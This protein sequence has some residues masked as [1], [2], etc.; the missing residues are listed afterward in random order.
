MPLYDAKVANP[1]VQVPAA[2]AKD[3][4]AKAKKQST[5][6]AKKHPTPPPPPPPPSPPPPSSDFLAPR[7]GTSVIWHDDASAD[8]PLPLYGAWVGARKDGKGG[9]F[10][11]DYDMIAP[12]RLARKSSGGPNGAAYREI[13][14]IPGDINWSA[15]RD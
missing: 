11:G 14:A 7:S 8:D 10:T 15:V 3:A 13:T 1:A 12:G 4:A 9:Q 6:T 2:N 5:W